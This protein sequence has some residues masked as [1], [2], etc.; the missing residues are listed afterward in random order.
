MP[1]LNAGGAETYTALL[2]RRLLQQ[3]CEVS[4]ASGGGQISKQLEQDGIEQH[5]VPFRLHVGISTMLLGR[6][7]NK[8]KPDVVH[9]NSANAAVVTAKACKATRTPWVMTAHGR[10][11]RHQVKYQQFGE[12]FKMICVSDF[13]R[14]DIIAEGIYP[15][16][17]LTTIPNGVQLSRFSMT[18][19][20]P[21]IRKE[22][23]IPAEAF[24][25][26]LI[27]RM[28]SQH[29]KGHHSIIK[30]LATNPNC[31]DWHAILIGGGRFFSYFQEMA[32][33][34]GVAD[35]VHFLGARQ[36][37]PQILPW[38][39]AVALPTFSET[40]G[41]SL[42]EAMA[43]GKPTVAYAVGGV[44]ELVTDGETGF[45]V[46]YQDEESL[47]DRLVWLAAHP[48]EARQMG[49]AGRCRIEQHF[50]IDDMV[51]EIL[52][53]YQAARDSRS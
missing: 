22:L 42:A 31:K 24:T 21:D 32:Q 3:G 28:F 46:P 11:F 17:L 35:R 18:P 39:D 38:V 27:G 47:A 16:E 49:Q 33:S 8:L 36:D 25:V 12:A 34:L 10:L 40:F 2:A 51:E 13:L 37:I 19:A 29:R 44:P 14:N 48:T 26:G 1:R 20:E 6:L 30:I 50:T 5:Y 4:V 53:I 43:C 52:P 41:L 23:G 45:L 7:I 9:A 15:A